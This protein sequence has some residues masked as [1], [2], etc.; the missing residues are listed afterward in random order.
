[1]IEF[2][3]SV[4]PGVWALL[5]TIFGGVLLEFCK[6]WLNKAQEARE[7]RRDDRT[8]IKDL[9]DRLDKVEEEVT[10]WRTRYYDAQ[11]DITRLQQALIKAGIDVPEIKPQE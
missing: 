1:M 2:L 9:Q 5:G 10:L 7:E 8:I 3:A 4:P 11:I 6:R